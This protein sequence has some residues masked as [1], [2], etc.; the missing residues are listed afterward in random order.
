MRARWLILFGSFLA[1]LFDALEIATLSFAIPSI[2]E[3]F[4]I[5]PFQAGLVA[6]A[7]LIGMGVSGF[8]MGYVAD[9]FGRKKAL[10][11]CMVIFIVL[12]VGVSMA[13]NLPVLLGLRFLSGIGLGGVWGILSAYIVESWPERTRGKAAA[14]VLAAYPIGGAVAAVASGLFLPDWRLMFLV[15]GLSAVLPLLIVAFAFPESAA[16]AEEKRRSSKTVSISEVFTPQLRRTTILASLVS[17]MAF[18]AYYGASTWL[19]SYLATDRGMDP[20]AVSTFMTVLNLGMFVGYLVFGWIADRI[21]RRAALMLSFFGAGVLMP[22]YGVV[23]DNTLLLW[24]GPMYAFFMTFAGL[25]GSYLGELYPTRVRTTGAGLCFN[26]GR[27]VSAF[28]PMALGGL[29]SA[30]SLSFGLVTSGLGFLVS[31][32][33]MIALPKHA[34]EDPVVEAQQEALSEDVASR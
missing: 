1:Y 33:L 21:G 22:L 34:A 5:T 26:I 9:N 13:P 11:L 29:A 4:G 3:D 32:V 19:P 24:L 14:F 30:T 23:T 6:T 31:G 17:A 15:A 2:I 7:T 12:T 28:A 16:W 27:G 25:F 20:R 18:I 10:M 8:V